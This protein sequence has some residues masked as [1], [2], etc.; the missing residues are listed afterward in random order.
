[1]NL[2]VH[3]WIPFLLLALPATSSVAEGASALGWSAQALGPVIGYLVFLAGIGALMLFVGGRLLHQCTPRD[4]G[5]GWLVRGGADA[6]KLSSAALAGGS[7]P[8]D[9][10][11]DG[12][13]GWM[14]NRLP[15]GYD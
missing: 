3:N 9:D 6:S 10:S 5:E 11:A 2:L 15:A 14:P 13:D 1:M 12:P 8:G 7:L 4:L